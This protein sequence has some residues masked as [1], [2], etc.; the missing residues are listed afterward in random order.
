[1]YNIHSYS[2]V[3]LLV[4]ISDLTC[5]GDVHCSAL[6]IELNMYK[7][8]SVMKSPHCAPWSMGKSRNNSIFNLGTKWRRVGRFTLEKPPP[9]V[10][11]K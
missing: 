11:I 1:V 3:H 2:D 10:P 7:I 6:C 9:P 5:C 4:L 8:P